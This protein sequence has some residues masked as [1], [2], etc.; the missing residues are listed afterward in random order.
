[1]TSLKNIKHAVFLILHV[2]YLLANT[3]STAKQ[4]I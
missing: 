2:D 4:I 3:N 1:M